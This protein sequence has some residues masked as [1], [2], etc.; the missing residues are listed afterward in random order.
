[1]SKGTDVLKE[2]NKKPKDMGDMKGIGF[3]GK[4]VAVIVSIWL[5]SVSYYAFAFFLLGMIPSVISIIVDRGAGRFA[6]KTIM[7][8]NFTGLVPYLFDIGLNYEKSLAAQQLMEQVATWAVIYGFA[9]IGCIMIWIMPQLTILFFLIRA[10]IRSSRI[11]KEQK[12]LVDEWGEEITT[13]NN[14]I[15]SH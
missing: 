5:V 4:A 11:E 8:F 13:I 14:I 6:S 12:E 7:A 3:I 9:F 15:R 10:E 2:V 1:M